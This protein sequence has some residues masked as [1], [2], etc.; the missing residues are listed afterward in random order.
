MNAGMQTAVE[1]IMEQMQGWVKGLAALA[2]GVTDAASAEGLEQEVWDGG[3]RIVG[4]VMET[5]LQ[6]ALDRQTRPERCLRCGHWW[7]SKG[8]RERGL[9]TRVGAV[10]LRGPYWYCQKCGYG[11][12]SMD[13]LGT[14]SISRLMREL[15]CMLGVGMGSFEKAAASSQKLLG[16]RVSKD[17]IAH[18]CRREGIKAGSVA[19]A[20]APVAA[21]ADLVGSCDGT[22]VNTRQEGW[23]ELKGYL[24]KHEQGVLGRAY[25]ESVEDFGPRLRQ[26]A[27][28]LGVGQAGRAIFVS[29]AAEWIDRAVAVQL[30]MAKRIVDIWHAYQHVHEAAR[31]IHG[32]GTPQAKAWAQRWCEHLREHG[33]HVTWHCLRRV[34]YEDTDRQEALD[35]LLGYLDRN[36]DRMDY[37]TY[38]RGGYP[39]SSGPMESF[40]K[41]LGRR[42]KGGGMRWSKANV[43][44]MATMV[45]L[46]ST[47][48]WSKYWS[49]A[50]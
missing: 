34:R 8:R 28:A 20:V 37:P 40:C 46:W 33:G 3:R 47:D 41:Q 10:K 23:K 1:G 45:S 21:G 17:A 19:P 27:L 50:N 7:H 26:S 18:L 9:I 13:M 38:E 12:H 11:Q 6:A 2:E 43:S 30:P 16:M 48:E 4:K 39:I 31:K 29:D 42:L 35:A 15:L 24:W 22:M 5:M 49:A 44:P 32:E 25:L 14:Q 36:A